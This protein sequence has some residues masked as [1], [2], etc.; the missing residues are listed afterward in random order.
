MHTSSKTYL[1]LG[2]N[3]KVTVWRNLCASLNYAQACQ[4]A[5]N[6]H[7]DDPTRKASAYGALMGYSASCESYLKQTSS[8]FHP[9]IL[10]ELLST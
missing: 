1:T 10:G 8:S 5:Y 4:W 2:P 6:K 3:P 7:R 9:I